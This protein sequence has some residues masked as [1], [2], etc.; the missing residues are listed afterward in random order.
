MSVGWR[1]PACSACYAPFVTECRRCNA[2]ASTAPSVVPSVFSPLPI[3]PHVDYEE[4]TAGLRCKAC[5]YLALTFTWSILPSSG[6]TS[7]VTSAVTSTSTVT[8]CEHGRGLLVSCHEC[9]VSYTSGGA[10]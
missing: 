10:S 1:C 5:G 6:F 2:P 8:H 3:C 4:T 9:Q 7:D